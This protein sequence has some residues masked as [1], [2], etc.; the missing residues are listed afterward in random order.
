MKRALVIAWA[1]AGLALIPASYAL[2][3]G[4]GVGNIGVYASSP[5]PGLIVFKDYLGPIGFILL[6]IFTIN[7][8]FSYGVA[9]TNAVSRIWY[10]AARD[11]VILPKSISKIHP[12]YKTPGNAMT[13]WISISFLLDII[14]GIFFGP[15]TAGLILLTMAGIYIICVHVIANSALSVFSRTELKNKGESNLLLHV[16]AP[17]VSSIIGV[18]IIY[19]S[20]LATVQTY[21]GTPN[22]VNFAYLAAVVVS[23]LWV[24]VAGTIITLYYRAS[25]PDVLAKAGMYDAESVD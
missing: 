16:I 24:V 3:V 7:S 9:K 1:L 13:L 6:L 2:V 12:K 17:T 4:W 25:K 23:V 11:G 19:E 5:D 20:I 22:A 14:L 18:V 21:I 10:S 8:Y 15:T